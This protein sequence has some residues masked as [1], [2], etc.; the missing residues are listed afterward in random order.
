MDVILFNPQVDSEVV[1]S[2]RRRILSGAEFVDQASRL[3][4]WLSQDD[5]YPLGCEGASTQA[6]KAWR[7]F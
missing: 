7:C 2:K 3:M 6:L 5:R 4:D 1:G